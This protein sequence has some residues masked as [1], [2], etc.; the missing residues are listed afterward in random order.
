M[1]FYQEL[2][3]WI[4]TVIRRRDF[5]I[6]RGLSHKDKATMEE[7]M[8]YLRRHLDFYTYESNLKISRFFQMNRSRILSLLPGEGSGSYQKRHDQFAKYDDRTRQILDNIPS[9]VSD[10]S[11]CAFREPAGGLNPSFFGSID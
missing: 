7:H 1:Y 11:V 5:L 6:K 3:G 8:A 2:R 9:T 10:S 4:L